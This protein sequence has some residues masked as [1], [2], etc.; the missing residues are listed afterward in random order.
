MTSGT[1]RAGGPVYGDAVVTTALASCWG[2][3]RSCPPLPD[4]PRRLRGACER[5][6]AVAGG[7]PHQEN[8]VFQ[9]GGLLSSAVPLSGPESFEPK[10]H[11]SARCG[12]RTAESVPRLVQQPEAEG[13]GAR[14]D[15]ASGGQLPQEF[16]DVDPPRI[17]AAEQ[18]RLP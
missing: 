5:S 1:E 13:V 18:G 12:S 4:P 6:M 7:A 10:Q 15:P 14:P 9:R 3:I 17:L 2:A 16:R 11:I 8:A